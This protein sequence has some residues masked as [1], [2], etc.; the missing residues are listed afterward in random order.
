MKYIVWSYDYMDA[1]AG[2][3]TM[4]RLCHELNEAGQEAYVYFRGRNSEWNTPY[5]SGPFDEDWLAVLPE[6]VTNSPIPDIL[7]SHVLRWMLNTPHAYYEPVGEWFPFHQL[8]NTTKLPAERLLYL[9]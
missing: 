2:Q 4:H 3:K 9:P 7:D 8:F 1:S 6:I 5:Y